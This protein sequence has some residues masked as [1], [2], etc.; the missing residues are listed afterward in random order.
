MFHF[1]SYTIDPAR[2]ELRLA[3]EVV[4]LEPQVFDL[5]VYLIE[6][7]DRVVS[8]DELFGAVWQGRIVSEATLSSRINAARR[9]IGDTGERQAYIRTVP[10]KGFLFAGN[11]VRTKSGESASQ[12]SSASSP[13]EIDGIASKQK[14][15][16]C[17]TP[18]GVNLAVATVG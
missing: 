3:D 16:F 18:D 11:I 17:R 12:V 1:E 9:A 10:R 14:I 2:R 8:K 6:N 5:L 15:T 4:H 13:A 7:R